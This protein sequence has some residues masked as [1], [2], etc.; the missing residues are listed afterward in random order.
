MISEACPVCDAAQA[1]FFIESN[2]HN[3]LKC[4]GCSLMF[5]ENRPSVDEIRAFFTDEYIT[6]D[7]ELDSG[8]TSWRQASL[9]REAQYLK[10][11]F[12]E[13]ARL[14]DVGVASGVFAGQFVPLKDWHVEGV[15]PSRKALTLA[16]KRYKFKVRPGFLRDAHFDDG[17]FDVITSLDTF[18]FVTDP[19]NEMREVNR[20]L[21][22]GGYFIVE[23][24]GLNFRLLKNTGFLSRLIY[25]KPAQLNAGVHLFYYSRKTLCNLI[26]KFGFEQQQAYPEQSPMR[27]SFL[28]RGFNLLHFWV[29]GSI[30]RIT[31]GKLNYVAKEFIIFR[32]TGE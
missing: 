17:S 30:Y 21:R 12:P 19:M 18:Y 26:E 16:E 29:A 10:D 23:I 2:G 14:L 11:L 20:V 6:T 13:G 9:N 1:V 28:M 25:G 32:K 7:E 27:G 8:F 15:E 31:G 22:Q 5:V 4:Q 3:I 24:P